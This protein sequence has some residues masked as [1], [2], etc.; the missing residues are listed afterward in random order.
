[1]KMTT[2]GKHRKNMTKDELTDELKK[3]CSMVEQDNIKL[4]EQVKNLTIHVVSQQREL[5]KAFSV[6]LL[7]HPY[8]SYS[9]IDYDIDEFLKAFNCG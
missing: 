8:S 9:T 4:R 5:L 7:E 3:R 6:W 1:M 2:G